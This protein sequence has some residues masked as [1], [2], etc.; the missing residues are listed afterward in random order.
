VANFCEAT[1]RDE[2]N[3][4]RANHRYLQRLPPKNVTNSWK[5]ALL[6]YL[7]LAGFPNDERNDVSEYIISNTD[8]SRK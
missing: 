5:C 8:G 6:C 7:S 4:P 2:A 1:T 3:V